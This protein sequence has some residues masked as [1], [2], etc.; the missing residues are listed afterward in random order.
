MFFATTVVLSVLAAHSVQAQTFTLTGCHIHGDVEYCFLPNGSEVPWK[1]YEPRTAATPTPSTTIASASAIATSTTATTASA[2]K[3]V[4]ASVTGCHSHGN[5]QFCMAGE[6]EYLVLNSPTGTG[7]PPSQYSGCHAHG[8]EAFCMTESGEEVQIEAAMDE[9]E[10][11]E[12]HDHSEESGSSPSGNGKGNGKKNCHFHA[13]VE[14]CIEEGES[15]HSSDTKSCDRIDRNYNIPLRIGLLFVILA[16]SAIAVFSPILLAQFT[17]VT[18][19]SLAFTA[20]K[21]FGTGVIIATAFVHLLT[22]AQLMFA[23]ECLGTLTYEATTTAIAMAGAFLAFLFE[24]IG[25]RLVMSRSSRKSS[26][27][28]D[29]GSDIEQVTP[30]EDQRKHGLTALGHGHG[31]A[32][33]DDHFKVGVMEAGIIFHSILIGVTLV[34]AGDSFF[35]TLFIVIL[36]HQMFEGIALGTRIAALSSHMITK[37]GM[38]SA[39]AIITPIGMAIGTGVLK[40]FNGNSA[41]TI[42]AIGTLDALSAGILLWVGLVEMWSHDWL[43]GDLAKAGVV[44]TIVA[45]SFLLFGMILMSVLGKWA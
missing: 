16:T 10:S 37:F 45:L 41:S 28:T 29:H 12:T 32:K 20:L 42:V 19:N 24:Y 3:T 38:A 15:E 34:V 5:S 17:Q 13:G 26:P 8:S 25:G 39:F 44:K 27:G 36:F 6:T 7:N 4:P 14:H 23:N 9:E 30:K 40:Q 18:L 31:L 21:Q 35:I 33:S 2:S 1:T 11:H 43:H 22:H